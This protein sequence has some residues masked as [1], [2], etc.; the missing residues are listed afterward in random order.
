M[1]KRIIVITSIAA[2]TVASIGGMAFAQS[3]NEFVAENRPVAITEQTTTNQG[4]IDQGIAEQKNVE[5][6]DTGIRSNTSCHGDDNM[7]EIMKENGFEDMAVYM[8][9]GNFEAMNERMN[10]LSEEDYDNMLQLM[11]EN[12]YGN[13]AQ[14]MESIGR[15]G[16]LEMHQSMNNGKNHHA[17]GMGRMMGN[18]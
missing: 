6:G 1:K 11:N 2:I 9:E 17:G 13:M 4:A 12:G 14:M 5:Q 18:F 15:E 8:E 7:I 10:N 16:M 3:N